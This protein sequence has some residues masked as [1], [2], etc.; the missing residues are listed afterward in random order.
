MK[1][2]SRYIICAFAILCLC[3]FPGFGQGMQI[4]VDS[5][6][7]LIL[8]TDSAKRII[9]VENILE[10]Y[11]FPTELDYYSILTLYEI[12]K[13]NLYEKESPLYITEEDAKVKLMTFANQT[14]KQTFPDSLLSIYVLSNL[15]DDARN[16]NNHFSIDAQSVIASEYLLD[17]LIKYTNDKE[18]KALFSKMQI[19]LSKSGTDYYK[20]PGCTELMI[21]LRTMREKVEKLKGVKK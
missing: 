6:R 4:S 14:Y 15:I 13:N 3:S 20:A 12:R 8:K 5:L 2:I 21:S 9:R 10:D 16:N 11:Q 19:L 18:A 1:T 17:Y 7:N